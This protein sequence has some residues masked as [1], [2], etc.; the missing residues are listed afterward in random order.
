MEQALIY[1]IAWAGICLLF[2]FAMWD[3]NILSNYWEWLNKRKSSLYKI[4][5]LCMPC[6][7]LWFGTWFIYFDYKNYFIFLG[8]SELIIIFFHYIKLLTTK[9]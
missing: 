8:I 6:F 5:G 1:G 9:N 2:D 3:G 7:C 4:F